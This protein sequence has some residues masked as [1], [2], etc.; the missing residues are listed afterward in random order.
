MSA[1]TID[2]ILNLF[3]KHYDNESLL[4]NEEGIILVPFDITPTQIFCYFFYSSKIGYNLGNSKTNWKLHELTLNIEHSTT[5]DSNHNF[6]STCSYSY[7][8][9][10]TKKDFNYR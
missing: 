5:D 9:H 7:T 4:I 1:K 8:N 6:Y 3:H 10:L 2:K